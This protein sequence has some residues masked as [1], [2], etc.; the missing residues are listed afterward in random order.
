MKSDVEVLVLGNSHA[1]YAIDPSNIDS[2]TT[3]NLANVSQQIYFDKRLTKKA[4]AE[5]VDNLRYV[6]ISVDYHSLFTSSQGE[7]DTWSF[8]Y[9]G[10]KY[11]DHNY[12][13]SQVSPFLF[14]YGAKVSANIIWKQFNWNIKGYEGD[15]LFDIAAGINLDD[16]IYNGYLG[17]EVAE[18]SKLFNDAFY[19]SRA[20]A[21]KEDVSLNERQMVNKDL[22]DFI[23]FL[24]SKSIEPILFSSPTYGDYNKF[25]DEKQITRNKQNIKKICS[26]YNL[27]YWRHNEDKRFKKKDFHDPDHLNKVGAKKFSRIINNRLLEYDKVRQ[28]NTVYTK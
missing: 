15:F 10:I 6:M 9:N 11:K 5:G 1:T 28:H 18:T 2:F 12:F 25:L 20:N 27:V 13:M 23:L 7:R 14:G 17:M 8:Y 24:K 26:E 19:V 21:F 3:Y 4:I 16:T 22:I